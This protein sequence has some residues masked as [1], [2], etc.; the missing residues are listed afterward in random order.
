M[1]RTNVGL[2]THYS[3]TM[4]QA[5]FLAK[6]YAQTGGAKIETT[7]HTDIA[8]SMP[9][10]STTTISNQIGDTRLAK[11][12]MSTIQITIQLDCMGTQ[13]MIIEWVRRTILMA[14]K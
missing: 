8:A 13:T 3:T 10:A 14:T 12:K 2:T 5:N 9:I 6:S 7:S 1:T 4:G 11:R